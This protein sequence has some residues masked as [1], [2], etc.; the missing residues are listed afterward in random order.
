MPSRKYLSHKKRKSKS[1]KIKKKPSRKSRS[2]KRSKN[3]KRSRRKRVKSLKGGNPAEEIFLFVKDV[4]DRGQTTYSTIS[5]EKIFNIN[6]YEYQVVL[7]YNKLQNRM[8]IHSIG[9]V[10]F[11][12]GETEEL[13]PKENAF[14]IY[15]TIILFCNA[16]KIPLRIESVSTGRYGYYLSR[17]GFNQQESSYY[18]GPVPNPGD[19]GFDEYYQSHNYD[20]PVEKM[21][22]FLEKYS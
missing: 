10:P 22:D 1:L 15:R 5:Y 9:W 16:V 7:K 4:Y 18:D 20:M 13:P 11:I 14:I 21:G 17:R 6:G 3:L 12:Y 8:I 2:K 19:E